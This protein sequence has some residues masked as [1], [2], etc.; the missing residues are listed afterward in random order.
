MVQH[1]LA[2]VMTPTGHGHVAVAYLDPGSGSLLLQ[3][4]VAALLSVPFILR[5]RIHG[6]WLRLRGPKS[7][8]IDDD[9]A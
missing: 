8:Q 2:L 4:A 9:K 7:N 6:L 3:A 5:T 1:L